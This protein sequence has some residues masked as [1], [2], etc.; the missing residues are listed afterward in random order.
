MLWPRKYFII[1]PT[2]AGS[3]P[4]QHQGEEPGGGGDVARRTPARLAAQSPQDRA[5]VPTA[6]IR[7]YRTARRFRRRMHRIG[8]FR[9]PRHVTGRPASWLPV[10]EVLFGVSYEDPRFSR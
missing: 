2:R 6:A 9:R 10:P 5:Q 3:A 1:V 7:G 4:V 8:H